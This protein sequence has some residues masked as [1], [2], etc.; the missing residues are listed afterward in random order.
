V[1]IANLSVEIKLS[2]NT[3]PRCERCDFRRVA[4]VITNL[5]V[6]IKLYRNPESRCERCAFAVSLWLNADLNPGTTVS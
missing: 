3:E 2:R 1:I 4:V 5:S 6:E